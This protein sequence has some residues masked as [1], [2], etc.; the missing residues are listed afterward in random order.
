MSFFKRLTTY[1]QDSLGVLAHQPPDHTQWQPYRL[2]DLPPIL[3]LICGGDQEAR[4]ATAELL[5]RQASKDDHYVVVLS[6]RQF[7]RYAEQCDVESRRHAF[8]AIMRALF[9][10]ECREILLVDT[11]DTWREREQWCDP[12]WVRRFLYLERSPDAAVA[13]GMIWQYGSHPDSTSNQVPAYTL[14]TLAP[15]ESV[16][17]TAC[18]LDSD[19]TIG[20]QWANE[21]YLAIEAIPDYWATDTQH[22]LA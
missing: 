18:T 17:Y 5:R 6:F 4:D 8:K 22:D 10:R 7:Q 9:S 3:T 1:I 12:R 13:Q 16:C 14:G 20:E 2:T 21:G 11:T 19:Q 15:H